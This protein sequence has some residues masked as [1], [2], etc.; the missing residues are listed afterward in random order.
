MTPLTWVPA[1]DRPDLLA[2][3][4]RRSL[5]SMPDPELLEVAEID[6]AVA[7]TQA[8]VD[9]S[10]VLLEDCA[11]CI[12][13]AGRRGQEERVA[14]VLVLATTRADVNTTVR[15]AL[16]A[17]RASFMTMD[18]AVEETGMEYGGITPVGLPE[19]WPVLVDQQVLDR[20]C[21]VIGSGV[22]R[23][24]LRLPGAAVRDLPAVRIVADLAR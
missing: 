24:K 22:R 23:S 17:R 7:D 3:P 19:G 16:D 12:V 18:R 20:A 1:A 11:N 15:K 8:L 13:V 21:V 4:V 10:D 5:H 2:E 6:P 14:A 9:S